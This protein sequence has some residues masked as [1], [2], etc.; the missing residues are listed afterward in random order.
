MRRALW[1]ASAL[2]PWAL[3]GFNLGVEAGKLIAVSG[4]ILISQAVV[5]RAWYPRVVVQGG[6]ALL[7]LLAATWFWQ[8]VS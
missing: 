7:V 8:R 1:L 3:G 6:S 4:W 5:G 2:L